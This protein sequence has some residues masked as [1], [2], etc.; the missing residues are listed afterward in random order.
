MFLFFH[1]NSQNPLYDQNWETYFQEDFNSIN[2]NVWSLPVDNWQPNVEVWDTSNVVL[3]SGILE[4]K[5]NYLG[6]NMYKLGALVNYYNQFPYGYYEIKWEVPDL[7][8]RWVSFWLCCGNRNDLENKWEELDFFE[9][10]NETNPYKYHTNVH[11]I[12]G[13]ASIPDQFTVNQ[14]ITTIHNIYGFEWTPECIIYYFNNV[15]VKEIFYNSCTP[16]G[17]QDALYITPG[18]A[19]ECF[20]VLNSNSSTFI[21]YVKIWTLKHDDVDIYITNNTLLNSFAYSV[22]KSI[23][24]NGTRN[25]LSIPNN[26]YS[27]YR[28][29]D[30]ISISGDFTVPLGSEMTLFI[31]NTPVNI[32]N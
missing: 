19:W 14:N 3:N 15:P 27:T 17:T 12:N 5:A 24:F 21:D 25:S 16:K 7:T 22:K 20:P 4:L 8:C 31:H 10:M 28:A 1:A 18:I 11:S 26:T 6:N 29:T 9:T 23:T 2:W 13:C 32:D 30:F